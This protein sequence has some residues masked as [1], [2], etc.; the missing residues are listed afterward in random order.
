MRR[1]DDREGRIV[2]ALFI[3]G[4]ACWIYRNTGPASV[5][6]ELSLI[7][8]TAFGVMALAACVALA[9]CMGV[10]ADAVDWTAAQKATGLKGTAGFIRSLKELGKDYKR[11]G[12][13]PYW[14]AWKGKREIIAD[15]E[16]CALTVGTSGSFKSSAVVIPTILTIPHS[17]FVPDFKEGALACQLAQTLRDEGE[18]VRILNFAN[19]NT[20]I[21]G[22]SDCYN[23][24][25]IITDCF[26]RK[27]GL[28][29]VIELL[30][31]EA[32]A[33]YPE[34]SEADANQSENTYFRNGSR[35][36]IAWAN[37]TTRVVDGEAATMGDAAMLLMNR[38]AM[39]RHAL[40]A[41]GR[42][43]IGGADQ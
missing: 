29:E 21:L 20:D 28:L 37:L 25:H 13:G 24:A 8:S 10:L 19:K 30:N 3:G 35:D 39:L 43:F 4:L 27:G 11:K 2:P 6:G 38:D 5:A 12:L 17:K 9:G 14:G 1:G 42:L 7:P 16:S 41:C 18:T 31:E 26:S 40:W 34:P 23:P 33:I 32:E 22:E 15:F 36:L